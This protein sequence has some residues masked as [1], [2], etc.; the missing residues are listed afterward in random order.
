MGTIPC[1]ASA[2]LDAAS[3]VLKAPEYLYARRL[4]A[5]LLPI[6]AVVAASSTITC[7]K[8]V[9]QLLNLQNIHAWL[10]QAA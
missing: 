8:I 4:L 9:M 1:S 3:M 2:K 6:R 7:K 10:L 5:L